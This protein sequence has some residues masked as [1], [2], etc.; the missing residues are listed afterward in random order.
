MTQRA[1]QYVGPN[2]I[3]DV[4]KRQPSGTRI[5]S[6]DQLAQW[7]ATAPTERTPHQCW[8]ATFTISLAGSLDLAPRRS[9][10]VACAAGGPVLSAGEITFDDDM[11]VVE[12]SNQSTGFCPEPESWPAVCNALDQAGIK[13]PN[14]FTTEVIFRRCTQCGER[15][16]VKDSWYYCGICD[17]KLPSDWNFS[18][19]TEDLGEQ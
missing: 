19:E 8:I 4:A 17:A 6:V 3:A 5:A 16:I 12:I 15:N 18:C 11:T 13:H 10:H 2:E 14:R 1:Y 9:E 7:L